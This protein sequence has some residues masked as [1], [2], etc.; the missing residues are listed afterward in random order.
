MERE[1]WILAVAVAGPVIG[2]IVGVAFPPGRKTTG[3][4]LSFAGGSMLAISFLEL[5]PESLAKCGV[6]G[7]A[8]GMAIGLLTMMTLEGML[9]H[10]PQGRQGEELERASVLMILGI[11]LHN[12]PEGMA[13]ASASS[14]EDPRALVT[15][16]FAI[17][18]H[19]IPEGICT[20]APYY[21]ATGRR[22]RAFLW[23]SS[24]AL[25]M[26]A[27]YLLGKSILRG[28]SFYAMGIMVASVA[29]LMIHISCSELLPTA[30][31][32]E[33]RGHPFRPMIWLAAGILFVIALGGVG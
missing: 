8:V 9:P 6:K 33:G 14:M 15:I 20:S 17:A 18:V 7:T 5:L 4:M 28:L 30:L 10:R 16:A 12:L 3:D 13:I 25:P 19:N 1:I 32:E 27:G 23:S 24:T 11:F 2:S 31:E 29:G 26:L 22:L 21:Q